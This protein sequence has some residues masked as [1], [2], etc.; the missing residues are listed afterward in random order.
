MVTS[1]K[2]Q[3]I[4]HSFRVIRILKPEDLNVDQDFVINIRLIVERGYF[5]KLGISSPLCHLTMVPTSQRAF[6]S[7]AVAR[8]SNESA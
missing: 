3:E 8:E 4:N 1:K 7:L 2:L 6:R 5:T